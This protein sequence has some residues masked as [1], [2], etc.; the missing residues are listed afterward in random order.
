MKRLSL[1][2]LTTVCLLA[3]AVG[4]T[5]TLERDVFCA[6]GNFAV[7]PATGLSLSYTA[8][9]SVIKTGQS[10]FGSLVLTQGFQQA[11][12]FTVGIDDPVQVLIDFEVYPNPTAG[13]ITIKLNADRPAIMYL[14]VMDVVGQVVPVPMQQARFNRTYQTQM[15]L[16]GLSDGY[17]L[18]GIMDESKRLIQ[19]IRIEK[20][21]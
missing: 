17:Y 21:Y 19:T 2:T 3:S 16:S 13:M 4:Q 20:V 1:L 18:L 6:F 10:L 15:D 5:Y 11:E 7:D 9:E 8:G 12:G 14:V